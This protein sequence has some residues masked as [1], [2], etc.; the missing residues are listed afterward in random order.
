[1]LVERQIGN[2]VFEAS[3]L[4]LELPQFTQFAYP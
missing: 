4:S 2:P 3:I 1:M